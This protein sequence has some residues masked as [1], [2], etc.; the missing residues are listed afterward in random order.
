ML[1]PRERRT[2]SLLLASLCSATASC[3]AAAEVIRVGFSRAADAPTVAAGVALVPINATVRWTIEIEPGIYRG[4]VSTV[5][6]GPLSLVGLGAAE[7]VVLAFGCSANKGNGQPGC[8]PCPAAAG[9]AGRATLTVAS[10]DFVGVNL[11]FANDACGYNAALAAQSEAV[12]LGA[13]RALFAHCRFLG[14]QDTLYTGAGPLRSY[15][16]DSFVNGSCDSIYGD[17][18]SV[19]EQCTITIVD[20]VTAHGGGSRCTSKA[21]GGRSPGPD[22]MC[23]VDGRGHGSYYL[24]LNASLLKPSPHEFDRKASASTELG[25]AWGTN[26]RVIFKDSF[27]DSHIAPHG[28]GCMQRGGCTCSRFGPPGSCANSS[29]CYCQNTTFAEYR[30]RGPGANPTKRVPWSR[31]LTE[32]EAAAFSAQAALRGWDPRTSTRAHHTRA[33]QE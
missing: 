20:H 21:N 27:L 29:K 14:G 10:A 17:S 26:A 31:Q 9:F 6:K 13:D 2:A 28:W 8:S 1:S 7:D 25:R 16:V 24:F 5:D 22:Q 4:R 15:F 12:S 19:F 18:T 32:H 23:G 30:S 3:A 11:T 33:H